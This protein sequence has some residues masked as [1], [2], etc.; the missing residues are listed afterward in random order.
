MSNQLV[1][2]SVELG[3]EHDG[4]AVG[5]PGDNEIINTFTSELAY[6]AYLSISRLNS[7]VYIDA[8]LPNTDLIHHLCLQDEQKRQKTQN[9]TEKKKLSEA[10]VTGINIK[11][12]EPKTGFN[13]SSYGASFN[14][15]VSVIGNQI[16]I[17]QPVLSNEQEPQS[18]VTSLNDPITP[19]RCVI[20]F[21]EHE[22][23][24]AKA[25]LDTSCHL[26][27]N[28]LAYWESEIRTSNTPQFDFKHINL[29]TLTGHTSTVRCLLGL[30]NETAIISGSKDKSVKL[31]TIKNVTSCTANKRSCQWTY[32]QHKKPVF[33]LLFIEGLR[34]CASCDGSVHVW[35]PFVGRK[36]FQLDTTI[37]TCMTNVA[38]PSACFA[39][40][41]ADNVVKFAD[42]RTKSYAY[43]FRLCSAPS[44]SVRTI[45]ASQNN[46]L[47]VGFNTGLMCVLDMRN[48]WI[49]DTWKKHDSELLQTK[50]LGGDQYACSYSD[51]AVG[52]GTV[53][54]KGHLKN[55]IKVYNEP[56]PFLNINDNNQLITGT[57]SNKIGVHSGVDKPSQTSFSLS[58]LQPENFKG[59]LSSQTYLPLNNLL[60]L[61]ADNGDIRLFS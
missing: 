35:D 46:L 1:N 9:S 24:E 59:V 55:L 37:A 34:M 32:G 17:S 38:A 28:W 3:N 8:I 12:Y 33:N 6:T 19:N 44:G 39:V 61:G 21:S 45:A 10:S 22:L 31:W 51:G 41:T 16:Q 60:L 25:K 29:L 54:E 47:L 43:E 58:K 40:A 5:E 56:V 52:V 53:K 14:E 7:G 13:S 27:D 15:H 48:G 4:E 2:E 26:S 23:K 49:V 11:Q 30:D 20:R 50:F 57:S 36:L 18:P 42:L